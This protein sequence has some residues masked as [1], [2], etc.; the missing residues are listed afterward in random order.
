[1]QY[2]P[3]FISKD[4]DNLGTAPI[5]AW[6]INYV[7]QAGDITAGFFQLPVTLPAPYQDSNY[8]VLIT[9]E[10]ASDLVEG[11]LVA[12]PLIYTLSATGFNIQQALPAAADAGDSFNYHLVVF[13]EEH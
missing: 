5:Q 1:M 2:W 9:L 3:S 10:L 12:E 4:A 6:R 7:L 11:L 8:S 13:R